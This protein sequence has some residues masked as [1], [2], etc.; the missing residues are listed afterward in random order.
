MNAVA[1]FLESSVGSGPDFRLHSFVRL[2]KCL[3]LFSFWSQHF[4]EENRNKRIT[5]YLSKLSK[6]FNIF[7][8][9]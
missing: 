1:M 5:I 9:K 4:N 6:Q 2:D 7:N 3:K 8:V